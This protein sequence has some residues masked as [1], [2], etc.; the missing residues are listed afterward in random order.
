MIEIYTP[1]NMFNFARIAVGN[2]V[3]VLG[4]ECRIAKTGRLSVI[5]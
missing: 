5:H 2:S 4:V 3:T 1:L